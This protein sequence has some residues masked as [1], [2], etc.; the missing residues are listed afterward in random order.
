[1]LLSAKAA[2]AT[3]IISSSS[4]QVSGI[5]YVEQLPGYFPVDDAHPRRAMRPYGLSKRLGE[6]LCEGF[7][8]RT[9]IATVCLRPVAVWDRARYRQARHQWRARPRSEREPYREYGAFADARDVAG[10]ALTAPLE[11]HHRV[12]LCATS[13]A[14]TV[15][16]LE[17]ASRLAPT[18][19]AGVPDM[20][21]PAY[22]E[23]HE[24][25]SRCATSGGSIPSANQ[26]CHGDAGQALKHQ[27][28]DN[29]TSVARIRKQQECKSVT[30]IIYN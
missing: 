21:R 13:I 25:R 30:A 14:A 11:R 24:T 29:L 8:R 22:A 10:Q 2:G 9:G 27:N 23:L 3:R 12:L 4:A 5:A 16:S 6:D 15:P 20:E 7:T 26:P 19:P 18:C 28:L 1:V 17:L